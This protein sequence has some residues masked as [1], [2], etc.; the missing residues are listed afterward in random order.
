MKFNQFTNY[1]LLSLYKGDRRRIEKLRNKPKLFRRELIRN[2]LKEYQ[3]VEGAYEKLKE[4]N[5]VEFEFTSP[6]KKQPPKE[7]ENP[8]LRELRLRFG[9]TTESE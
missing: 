3:S 4:M 6:K 8:A 1:E 7:A 2:I 9:D 5:V